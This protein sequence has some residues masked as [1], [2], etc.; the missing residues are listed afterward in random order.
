VTNFEFFFIGTPEKNFEQKSRNRDQ[1]SPQRVKGVATLPCVFSRWS[2]WDERRDVSS[3][4]R[5]PHTAQW[6]LSTQTHGR[7]ST[8]RRSHQHWPQLHSTMYTSYTSAQSFI[9]PY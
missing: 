5:L 9:S 7:L 8:G 4:W 2:G 1:S 6:R 3:F